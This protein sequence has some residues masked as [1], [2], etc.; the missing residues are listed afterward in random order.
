MIHLILTRATPDE[1]HDMLQVF[2]D[3][4][5]LAVDVEREVL[6]GGGALHA[7]C[8]AVLL[9]NGSNN[10]NVWG[11]DWYPATQQLSFEAML[12][13]RPRLGNRSMYLQNPELRARVTRVVD[14]LLR[15]VLS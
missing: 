11:A 4:I 9:E 2:G 1:L 3:F 8:E 7:D 5:K 15:G 14:A 12:N 6:A 13:I 10:D